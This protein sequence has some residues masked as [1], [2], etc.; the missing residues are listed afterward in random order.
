MSALERMWYG[1]SRWSLPLLPLSWM[2]GAVTGLRR[3]LYRRGWL[4][5]ERLPVPVVVIGN[6]TVGGTGKTPLLICLAQLLSG[7]GYK[8]GI[9]SRGYGGQAPRYPLAVDALTAPQ[10]GGDEPALIAQS[11]GLPVVVDPDRPRAARTLLQLHQVNVILSDDGLQH[12]RLARDYEIATVDGQ[13]RLGNARLLPA[14]PLREPPRRLKRVDCVLVNGGENWEAGFHLRQLAARAL[15]DGRERELAAFRGTPVHAI[16]GIG[17]PQRF[18]RQL[19]DLGLE[20]IAH[21]YS[22]HHRFASADLRFADDHPVLMTEKDAVKCR[23]LLAQL[24]VQRYW[25]VP[26]RAEL[27]DRALKALDGLWRR[28]PAVAATEAA[29]G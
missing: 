3:V 18:F 5:A 12:Y 13:R 25:Y 2:F 7:R 24:E 27:N 17:H 4:R 29:H 28:L 15:H 19:R 10:T 21:P 9:V 1:G 14:G 11:T 8:V 6:I 23:A 16:A 22:D 20:V 26:V